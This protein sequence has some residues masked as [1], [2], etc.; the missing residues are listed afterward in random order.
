MSNIGQTDGGSASFN[1]DH[2]MGFSTGSNTAGYRLSNVVF[3]MR[4]TADPTP[5]FDVT[6]WE[7]DNSGVLGDQVATLTQRDDLPSSFGDVRFEAGLLGSIRGLHL[8]PGSSHYQVIIDVT[9]DASGSTLVKRTT[10]NNENSGAETGF[11][12][13]NTRWWRTASSTSWNS[14]TM[15]VL[16]MAVNGGPKTAGP[17]LSSAAVTD[18]T[19]T[20]TFDAQLDPNSVPSRRQFTVKVAG[21]QRKIADVALGRTTVTLTLAS[22][23]SGHPTDSNARETVTVS[24]A[25][26]E[27]T[28]LRNQLGDDTLDFTDEAVTNNTTNRAPVFTPD[29]DG[30][31]NPIANPV[32]QACPM[33]RAAP[34]FHFRCSQERDSA[35][36]TATRW[37]SRG[38]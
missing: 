27:Y 29:V 36:P 2:R 9:A 28:P 14:E 1:N 26:N 24:Y 38:A 25:R 31:G 13:F 7:S 10:S 16:Q 4:D 34:S 3:R 15:N 12:L 19:L 11:M 5:S 6:V 21:V 23:V 8:K 17:A 35:T 22:A 30:N 33:H 18:K 32:D 20:L 37:T